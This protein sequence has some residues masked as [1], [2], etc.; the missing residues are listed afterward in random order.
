MRRLCRK[1]LEVAEHESDDLALRES[2]FF[3][4]IRS[5]RGLRHFGEG[6]F[7]RGFLRRCM[8]HK[9]QAEEDKFFQHRM[10]E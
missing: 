6:E 4:G 5:E 1:H 8:G 7:R 10:A 9:Q 2:S 3:H